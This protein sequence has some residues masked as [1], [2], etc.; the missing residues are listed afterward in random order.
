MQRARG[1]GEDRDL[2][3]DIKKRYDVQPKDRSDRRTVSTAGPSGVD[4]DEGDDTAGA[5]SPLRPALRKGTP[6]AALF[7]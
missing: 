2:A 6:R 1:G 7:V 3:T 5:V 4:G